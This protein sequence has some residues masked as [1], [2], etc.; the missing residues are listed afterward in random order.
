[1]A[2]RDYLNVEKRSDLRDWVFQNGQ[3][4]AVLG[5]SALADIPL[6][7]WYYD[8][9]SMAVDNGTDSALAFK[10]NVIAS[11]DP[12]RY[13]PIMVLSDWN[14]MINKPSIAVLPTTNSVSVTLNSPSV[15][16]STKQAFVSY[17]VACSVTNPLLIG[18]ST[19]NAYLEYSTNGGSTWVLVAQTGNSSSIGVTVAV[20]FTNGQTGNLCGYIP[21]NAQRRIRT[22]TTGTASV[23][24]VSGQETY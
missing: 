18:S 14:K 12:G 11:T 3:V 20:Q 17:S 8:E 9:T 6:E 2:V 16:S 23:T 24:F 13:L 15:I 5:V 10:P 7:S 21:A 4:I 1:M 19:A 22:S